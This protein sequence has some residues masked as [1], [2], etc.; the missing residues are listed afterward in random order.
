M[1]DTVQ[2]V[3]AVL[4]RKKEVSVLCCVAV[5]TTEQNKATVRNPN[6]TRFSLLRYV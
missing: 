5:W 3:R 1:F 4:V 2:Y 6:F